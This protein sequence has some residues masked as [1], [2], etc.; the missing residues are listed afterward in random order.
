MKLYDFFPYKGM[1]HKKILLYG[2]HFSFAI[3]FLLS[4]IPDYFLDSPL[5]LII[6]FS[7]TFFTFVSYY[8]LH[9][10]KREL[11][12]K[13]IITILT[14][15]PLF[16][17]IYLNH[18]S[19]FDIVYVVLL[20]LVSFYLY[21]LRQAIIINII[22]YL[23]IGALFFYIYIVDPDDMIMHNT[24]ALVNIFFATVFV[25]FFGLFYHFGIEA[26]LLKLKS[27]NQQKDILLQEVHHRV[28]N[29]LNVIASMLGLQAMYESNKTK[30]P[31]LKSKSRIQAIAIVHELLYEHK[32][33]KE[34]SFYDYVIK[35]EGLVFG[36]Y[37]RGKISSIN[38]NV[39]KELTLSL[40]T[41]V[42]FGLIINEMLINTMKYAKND[43]ALKV[44][45]SLKKNKNEFIFIYSDNG[46][47]IL[48]TIKLSTTK[49][50]GTKLIDLSIK[51]LD[52]ELK[53]YYNDGLHYE[54]RFKDV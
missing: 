46:E 54:V 40:N 34:I 25:M 26:S 8:L 11:T 18:S 32:N 14:I 17:L 30:V 50:L 44:N 12:S 51:Q 31:L 23:L 2:F 19:H 27:S 48:D 1:E 22:I 41:M 35:L 3:V 37:E 24:F 15:I 29:N 38:I 53:K 39:K 42:Q 43:N 13:I 9:Y 49:G 5:G 45:I 16:S 21:N 4:I 6:D 47:K 10:K 33:F 28:K 20:P 52:G 7:A 36:I